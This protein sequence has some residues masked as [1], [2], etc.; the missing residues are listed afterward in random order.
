VLQ[1][2]K[3]TNL[4]LLS[5]ISIVLTVGT[6]QKAYGQNSPE[7]MPPS[8]RSP[9]AA[10]PQPTPAAPE[11][12][13]PT[14]S[15][16]RK[17]RHQR[18]GAVTI[19][20]VGDVHFEQPIRAILNA[21]PAEVFATVA[22]QLHRADLAI[23]NLETAITTGGSPEP[24]RYAFRAPATAF[25]AL[26][27]AGFSV[28][29]MANNHGVDFGLVGLQ[30]TLAAAALEQFRVI[31]IGEDAVHAYASFNVT[32]RGE[33]IAFLAATQVLDGE[34][35]QRWTATDTNPGLASAKPEFLQRFLRGVHRAR[36]V[37]DT[38]IVYLHWGTELVS[39]PTESQ[40][41]LAS[42]LVKAG[43]D[44][45]V[46]SHAHVL[47]GRGF[48]DNTFVDYGLGNFAFYARPGRASRTGIL[49][50]TAQGHKIL[51]NIWTP[52]VIVGGLPHPLIGTA[53]AAASQA[54]D[55][56]RLCTNL[57]AQPVYRAKPRKR[58]ARR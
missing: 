34:L 55:E 26:R 42:E 16:T 12:S 50:V 49:T 32:I 20:F 10:T 28:V 17:S 29:T 5:S 7:P 51:K 45:I 18:K 1:K 8:V 52:A 21:D 41:L 58:L 3:L 40:R 15:S 25:V 56:L 31:G 23:A 39:C 30:D 9:N 38:V 13:A 4:L 14:R 33:H 57:S 36:A 48:L 37:S 24:K 11:K 47:L 22:P 44:I 2:T 27:E 54:A 6:P 35:R 43:A 46:G 19:A 53:A